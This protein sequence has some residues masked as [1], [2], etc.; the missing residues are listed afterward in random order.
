MS[1][2]LWQVE[3]YKIWK[4]VDSAKPTWNSLNII[5]PDW[6][7]ANGFV[8]YLSG[9][10]PERVYRVKFADMQPIENYREPG[11]FGEGVTVRRAEPAI[12]YRTCGT[13]ELAAAN[14]NVMSY[15]TEREAEIERLK[16]DR[17]EL[18][19][20]IT[21][22]EDAPGLLDSLP[23]DQLIEIARDNAA[24]HMG[25]IDRLV[26]FEATLRK[27]AVY[28]DAAANAYLR[29]TGEYSA[30]DE[31][32][33]VEMARGALEG[34]APPAPSTHVSGW[35]PVSDV[36]RDGRKI[37]VI[38]TAG[39]QSTLFANAEAHSHFQLAYTKW[40]DAAPS[41]QTREAGR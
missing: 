12:D 33:A 11:E 2:L 35:L 8:E 36:P 38:D 3:E 16:L 1:K 7:E 31:P 5:C 22:G 21:G 19:Y 23:T 32:G 41:P 30:F 14:P 15:V 13:A 39:R 10:N 18:A 29:A 37:E 17:Y 20:A 6:H 9:N 4:G 34:G 27:I 24:R 26:A 40:R 25:D 28:D